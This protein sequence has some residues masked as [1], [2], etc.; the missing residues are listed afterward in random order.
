MNQDAN[1]NR[2]LF[3]KELSKANGVKGEHCSRMKDENGRHW[4][5]LKCEGFG[6]IIENLY[7]TDTK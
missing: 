2:K 6:R 4:E 5:R 7:N 3:W 1:G